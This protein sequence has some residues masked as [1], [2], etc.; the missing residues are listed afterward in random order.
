MAVRTE[1]HLAP[2]TL[3]HGNGPIRRPP[4]ARGLLG[5]Q[6]TAGNRAVASL[7]VQRT[8]ACGCGCGGAGRCGAAEEEVTDTAVTAQRRTLAST[9][10]GT[11]VQRAD[12]NVFGDG[13]AQP[14]AMKSDAAQIK[15]SRQTSFKEKWFPATE[16][17]KVTAAGGPGAGTFGS[18]LASL[19]GTSLGTVNALR[20]IGHA[21]SDGG[22]VLGLA[23]KI[24]PPPDADVSFNGT[25]DVSPATVTAHLATITTLRDRFAKGGKIILVGCNAG[26]ADPLMLALATAFN[27]CVEGF[28]DEVTWCL[29]I[30]ATNTKIL[31]RGKTKSLI[32]NDPLGGKTG[33]GSV[34]SLLPDK[35]TCPPKPETPK[36]LCV[37]IGDLVDPAVLSSPSLDDAGGGLFDFAQRLVVGGQSD[38]VGL[39]QGDGLAFGT[40]DRKERVRHL[41][42]ALNDAGASL[43]ADGMFGGGTRAAL[44]EFQGQRGLAPGAEVDQATADSLESGAAPGRSDLVGLRRGDGLDFGTEGRAPRVAKLQGKLNEKAQPCAVDGMFGPETGGALTSFQG[45]NGLPEQELV[46]EP[47]A[48]ALEGGGGGPPDVC[49]L[50]TVPVTGADA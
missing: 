31:S 44:T 36:K 28:S 5:L 9:T 14:P 38:L 35:T 47:T 34:G 23:G 43:S 4:A 15:G 26:S 17:F 13:Y 19:K 46:D 18:L 20:I 33:C 12:L 16:D 1:A 50:G 25:D 45:L 7:M 8:A 21:T 42:E 6:A 24:D 11:Q 49:P 3:A 39:R 10:A 2:R 48:A 41:Q 32:P 30:N 29:D 22:G 40:S 27:V 37:P